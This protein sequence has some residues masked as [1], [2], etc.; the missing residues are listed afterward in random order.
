MLKRNVFM[1]NADQWKSLKVDTEEGEKYIRYIIKGGKIENA[2]FERGY[3]LLSFQ[4]NADTEGELVFDKDS[5]I[6]L[7]YNFKEYP[8]CVLY[9]GTER[10][11]FEDI[12]KIIFK[13]GIIWIRL[14]FGAD[15]EEFNN[16]LDVKIMEN[17]LRNF[18][19][20]FNGKIYKVSYKIKG[21][22]LDNIYLD[23]DKQNI[24]INITPLDKGNITLNLINIQEIFPNYKKT[25]CVISIDGEL[26]FYPFS[27]L[28]KDET[29]IEFE[30]STKEIKI[31][32]SVDESDYTQKAI[33]PRSMP[34]IVNPSDSTNESGGNK[35]TRQ[36]SEKYWDV[37]DDLF[38]KTMKIAINAYETNRI[39]NIII[40]CIGI[41]L[42]INSV[43]YTWYH[44]YADSWSLFSGGL[45][46]LSFVLVF[47][48]NPQIYITNALGNLAQIQIIYKAQSLEFE[49]MSDYNWSKF[50]ANPRDLK[51]IMLMNEELE[52][53]TENIYN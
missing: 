39:I 33:A 14:F 47:F 18:D 17:H 26:S 35:R 12:D 10:K 46:L 9:I 38:K 19:L 43:V 13:K 31:L 30:T 49:S 36:T 45:G 37:L 6:N 15:K 34:Q 8:Q 42:I 52:R 2:L 24:I 11:Y 5:L 50:I 41:I 7:Y 51:E 53:T 27:I 1:T 23:L 29:N 40:V 32:V 20:K 25:G 44:E 16:K 3:S 21:G 28:E 22:F 4:I 48:L